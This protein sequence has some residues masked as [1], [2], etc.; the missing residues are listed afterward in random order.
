MSECVSALAVRYQCV[1][2][3]TDTS[4]LVRQRV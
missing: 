4:A 3:L 2:A 1:N